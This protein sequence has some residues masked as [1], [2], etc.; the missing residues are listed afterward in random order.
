MVVW[1]IEDYLREDNSQLSDKD[2]YQEVKGH[3]MKVEDHLMK[4]IKSVFRN[5]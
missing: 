2:A 4:A 5:V 3:L 1:D